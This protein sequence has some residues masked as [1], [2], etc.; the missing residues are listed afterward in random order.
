[1]GAYLQDVVTFKSSQLGVKFK[2]KDCGKAC[3]EI[4]Y[5]R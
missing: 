4:K 2:I 3:P 1:M 5:F